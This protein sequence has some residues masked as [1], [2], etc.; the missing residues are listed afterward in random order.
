V[1]SAS[2]GA[3]YFDTGVIE[4]AT[5]IIEIARGCAV[6]A[7]RCLWEQIGFVREELDAW[8]QEKGRRARLEGFSAHYNITVP[9]ER[10]IDK[11]GLH[12]L[13]LLLTYILHAPAM[14]LAA[15]G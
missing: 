7:G 8:E 1:A 3:L 10:G 9:E 12:Q 5:P 2:G 4:L 13:A 11:A 14:L 6:R 15:T